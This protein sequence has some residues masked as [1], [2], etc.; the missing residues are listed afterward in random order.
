MGVP[1]GLT[2][3]VPPKPIW[4][5]VMKLFKLSILICVFFPNNDNIGLFSVEF[6]FSNLIYPNNDNILSFL[7]SLSFQTWLLT[8]F[9]RVFSLQILTQEVIFE[10]WLLAA[11]PRVPLTRL[12]LGSSPCLSSL[13]RVFSSFIRNHV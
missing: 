11:F 2:Y 5:Y 3:S 10:T 4:N 1:C 7:L 9:P 8:A 6:E 13:I 12:G